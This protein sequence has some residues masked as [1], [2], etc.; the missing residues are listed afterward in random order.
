M[1]PAAVASPPLIHFGHH[2]IKSGSSPNTFM[3]L[4]ANGFQSAEIPY[5]LM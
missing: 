5:L 4:H 3:F 2:L 1:R